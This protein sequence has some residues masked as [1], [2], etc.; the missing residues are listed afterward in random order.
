MVG[1]YGEVL[2]VDWGLAKILGKPEHLQIKIGFE[3]WDSE[4]VN[5][6]RHEDESNSQITMVGQ[7]MGTP[8][9]MAPE[10]AKDA[11]GV[12]EK[13]DIYAMG[14][15]LYNLLTLR[16]PIIESSLQ[17]I[18]LKVVQGEIIDPAKFNDSN[19]KLEKE[20]TPPRLQHL[21]SGKIPPALT[22]VTMK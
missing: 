1:E 7:A 17:G 16:N 10:Q 21:Q 2:V 12:N 20:Q 22:S 15:V 9:Y 14:G 11:S 5:S 13:A 4:E 8:A 18:L 6:I 19:F 3:D